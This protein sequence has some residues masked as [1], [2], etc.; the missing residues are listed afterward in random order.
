VKIAYV[1]MQFPVASEAFAAVEIRALR[2]LGAELT[3]LAYRAPP[4][5]AAAML[6][7]RELGDLPLDQGGRAAALQGLLLVVRRPGDSGYLIGAILRHGWRRPLQLLKALALVPRSLALLQRVEVLRPDVLHLFWGHYP[8]LLGLLVK[9]KLP[10]TVVSLFLG[11]YDLEQRFPLSLVMARQADLLLTHARAN[12]PALAALGLP[13]GQVEVSY[14]GIEVPAPPPAPQKTR[15]LMVVAERLVPQK[16]TADALRVFA[17]VAKAIP[18]ARLRVLGD[19]AEAGAL[20]ALAG[21]L[22]IA[23]QVTFAGHVAHHDVL[24]QLAEAEVALTLSQSR[25]ERLPNALKEA[26]L[27]RCLCLATRTTGIEELIADGDSGLLVDFGDIAG[28]ARRLTA[29]L[30][31]PGEVARIG[32]RAQTRIAADFDIDRLMAGRLRR[33]SE[34]AA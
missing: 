18:E 1:T 31:D 28:A 21:Q 20:M 4:P 5:R 16:R 27:Q 19:G 3:V 30:R 33:W 24:R 34:A 8:S 11:A 10:R 6:A 2:R 26:M 14:R 13:P 23:R 22:G 15:G 9:R 29:A 25:S 17:A 12:L 7:E 32:G